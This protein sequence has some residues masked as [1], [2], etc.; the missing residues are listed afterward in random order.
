MVNKLVI[1]LIS[2]LF[3]IRKH[4][5]LCKIYEKDATGDKH[6]G[7]RNLIY[8]HIYFQNYFTTIFRQPSEESA[9]L[10]NSLV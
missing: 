3:W 6:Y 2:I 4:C 8:L 7:Y 9:V 5:S 10:L 1:S